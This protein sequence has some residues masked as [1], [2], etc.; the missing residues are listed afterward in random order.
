MMGDEGL[1]VLERSHLGNGDTPGLRR[2]LT[3]VV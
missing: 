1:T 3:R 2:A